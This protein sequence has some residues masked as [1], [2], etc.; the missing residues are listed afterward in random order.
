MD[1][2]YELAYQYEKECRGCAQSVLA[3]LQ[4]V[5]EMRDDAVFK[6]AS[7]LSGG[8]GLS[9]D[10][11]CGALSGGIMA[12]GMKFGRE[13][14]NFKDPDRKRMVAYRLGNRLCERFIEEY[15]STVCWKIQ[16]SHLGKEYD[17]WASEDYEEFDRIAYQKE[18]CP[19]LVANAARWT[20]EIIIDEE[21][22]E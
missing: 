19:Q 4:D 9:T 10:G 14:E 2:T 7:G 12:I 17:L 18:K 5:F 6:S 3:A 11:S 20:A 22:K 13:R 16:R 15:G 1:A 21:R 8:G